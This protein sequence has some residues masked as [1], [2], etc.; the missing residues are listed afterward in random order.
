MT[1]DQILNEIRRTAKLNDGVPLGKL[2]FLKETGIKESDW[3]GK[4]WAK[5]SDVILE[6]GY[7]PNKLQ[8]TIAD[9]VLLEKYA[10]LAIELG[11]LPTV[12]EL[13][14]QKKQDASFPN[15]K[16]FARLGSKTH[17]TEKLLAFCNGKAN[18]AGLLVVLNGLPKVKAPIPN[19]V[20]NAIAENGNVYLLKFG[21]VY[22]IGCSNNVERRFKE[23]RTQ[24]PDKGEIVHSI[25]TGD[26]QGIEAY[27]HKYFKDKQRRG[28]WFELSDTDVKYFMKRKLM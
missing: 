7:L 1:K 5:W 11:H 22:K 4:F 17:F 26:Q 8:E 16:T 10:L 25:A 15:D 23:I 3:S 13:R 28:E 18:F 6:A 19:G 24:M 9:E 12:S 27:W 2:R 14:L 20:I 21:Q